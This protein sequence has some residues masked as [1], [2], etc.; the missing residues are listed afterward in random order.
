MSAIDTTAQKQVA[1]TCPA[2]TQAVG[3]GYSIPPGVQV[4]STGSAQD[5]WNV[6][7]QATTID[8]AAAWSL[9]VTAVCL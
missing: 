1:A 4:V 9:H 6:V 8:P 5:A 7:A 3:G 2:G